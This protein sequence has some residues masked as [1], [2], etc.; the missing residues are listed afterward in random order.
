VTTLS[1]RR[2]RWH[3]SGAPHSPSARTS[4][5]VLGSSHLRGAHWQA[6]AFTLGLRLPVP[7]RERHLRS[8]DCA[9]DSDVP[10]APGFAGPAS[11]RQ[12][13]GGGADRVPF[14]TVP[15][16]INKSALKATHGS[17]RSSHH[18]SSGYGPGQRR[19]QFQVSVLAECALDLA[20]SASS[21]GLEGGGSNSTFADRTTQTGRDGTRP[22]F[23]AA[24]SSEVSKFNL[25]GTIKLR[26]P[27][28]QQIRSAAAT[29][30]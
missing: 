15:R 1:H 25:N 18:G 21:R 12:P 27:S 5:T 24:D 20:C 23:W 9:T 4:T 29:P 30:P 28:A 16:L 6:P 7:A 26:F 19:L 22:T 8:E 3:A 14:R 11:F 13:R 17:H 10:L 2:C